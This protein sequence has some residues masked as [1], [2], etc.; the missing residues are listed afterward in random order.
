MKTSCN[1]TIKPSVIEREI[2]KIDIL[3]DQEIQRVQL[4][5]Q[6]KRKI[7]DS[8]INNDLVYLYNEMLTLSYSLKLWTLN[9]FLTVIDQ[10]E[11]LL[12]IIRDQ[13]KNILCLT[14]HSKGQAC[15]KIVSNHCIQPY[16]RLEWA[17]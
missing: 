9:G 4:L 15:K 12:K 6:N 11:E 8:L 16:Q 1:S 5:L 13:F 2:E 3:L 17:V 7:D 10:P 14:G